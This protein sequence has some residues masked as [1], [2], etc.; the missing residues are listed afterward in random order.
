MG[1]LLLESG[2]Y[3]GKKSGEFPLGRFPHA[4]PDEIFTFNGHCPADNN[5]Q[6]YPIMSGDVYNGGISNNDKYGPH[7][8]IFYIKRDGDSTPGGNPT[9]YFCGGLT[10]EGMPKGSGKFQQCT[11]N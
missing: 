3:R 8:A 7:R 4:Y 6:E 5:R 11:V 9:V 2:V 10:H 1:T